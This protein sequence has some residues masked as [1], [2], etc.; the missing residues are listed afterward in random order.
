MQLTRFYHS[1]KLLPIWKNMLPFLFSIFF[2][3]RK[4]R[5][6]RSVAASVGK[7]NSRLLFWSETF[8]SFIVS[9]CIL[10]SRSAHR[11]FCFEPIF[12]HLDRFEQIAFPSLPYFRMYG[13]VWWEC[14]YA[15]QIALGDVELPMRDQAFY[16][17]HRNK[18][19]KIN[20]N[21]WMQWRHIE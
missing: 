1:L 18:L 6:S 3:Y 14:V 15:R 9:Q 20:S 5:C 16:S 12:F 4:K 11:S 10:L 7:I 13:F 2:F 8:F 21:L 19:V 17:I